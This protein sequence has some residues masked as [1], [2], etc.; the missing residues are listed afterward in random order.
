MRRWLL[1]LLLLVA[2]C[3]KEPPTML[4][5]A[6]APAPLEGDWTT[7]SCPEFGFSINAPGMFKLTPAGSRVSSMPYDPNEP[8]GGTPP[9]PANAPKNVTV[10]PSEKD[11]EEG[12]A[13][14]LYD[15]NSRKLPGEPSAGLFVRVEEVGSANLDQAA[16]TAKGQLRGI[17]V[18]QRVTLPIGPAHYFK[19]S[20][21]MVSG[22]TVSSFVFIVAHDKRVFEF[23]FETPNAPESIEPQVMPMMET[24][25]VSG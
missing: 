23:K 13:L 2:G 14:K 1:P 4:S 11:L 9:P 21:Q 5:T 7:Y 25:R 8:S 17:A 15:Q 24:L 20:R 16:K 10:S 22:E 19:C 3:S 12:I 6:V 18:E